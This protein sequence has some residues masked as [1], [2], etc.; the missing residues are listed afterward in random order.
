MH[1]CYQRKT[2][3]LL[4]S[5][6]ALVNATTWCSSSGRS[7]LNSELCDWSAGLRVDDPVRVTVAGV[8]GSIEAVESRRC[9]CA[10]ARRS[11]WPPLAVV[12][13]VAEASHRI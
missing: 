9:A 10:F 3:H 8:E 11:L 13:V 2:L 6:L 1:L 12:S 7:S 4:A 5:V